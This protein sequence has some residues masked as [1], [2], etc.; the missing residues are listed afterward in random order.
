MIFCSAVAFP[1][2]TKRW[3]DHGDAAT[4]CPRG[5]QFTNRHST[6][7]PWILR[8]KLSRQT[9]EMK[10]RTLAFIVCFIALL[11]WSWPAGAQMV[12]VQFVSE[13]A[14]MSGSPLPGVTVGSVITGE[15]T[16]DLAHL[17]ADVHPFDSVGEYSYSGHGPPGYIFQFT[18]GGQ[19]YTFD[20]VNAA[21]DGG[22]TPGIFLHDFGPS[23]E[24]MNFQA[25]SAGKSICRPPP[26]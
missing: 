8:C 24:S 6:E 1:I 25:R 5:T 7:R 10:I 19:T 13:V 14:S 23:G 17:P 16:V 2:T 3:H 15:V 11:Q 26:I 4:A 21:G 9:F 20:S 12:R 22:T 18:A